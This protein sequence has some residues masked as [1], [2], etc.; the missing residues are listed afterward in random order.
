[1]I[2]E[3]VAALV[4]ALV[5]S[6][7]ALQSQ[8]PDRVML[9]VGLVIGL[10]CREP[11]APA[12]VA[13]EPRPASSPCARDVAAAGH[14]EPNLAFQRYAEALDSADFCQAIAAFAP[15]VRAGVVE[16][17]FKGLVLLAGTD[18]PNRA[19]YAEQLRAFCKLHGL[20]YGSPNQVVKLTSALM[21]GR[22]VDAEL[23]AFSRLAAAVPEAT[24]QELMVLLDSVDPESMLRFEPTLADLEVS[25]SSAT[26]TAKGRDGRLI[27]MQFTKAPSGWFLVEP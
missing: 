7:R 14:A 6:D 15:E 16:A 26:A 19:R 25:S 27:P 5:R 22:P 10:A 11:A 21:N 17:A 24:Y 18:N 3:A 9:A 2:R 20:D 23:A 13:R 4:L 8:W 1:M 12:P